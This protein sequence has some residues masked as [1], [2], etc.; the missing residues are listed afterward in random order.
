[1]PGRSRPAPGDT[2]SWS[3]LPPSAQRVPGPGVLSAE[4]IH[5]DA[6]TTRAPVPRAC[7]QQG[8]HRFPLQFWSRGGPGF[9]LPLQLG[10]SRPTRRVDLA[11]FRRD[12]VASAVVAS[13][14]YDLFISHNKADKPFAERL[15]AA[16]EAD[17]NGPALRVFLDK[18]DIG[19][20]ADIPIEL[21]R[22]L[23][24]SRHIGLVLSPDSLK[25]Q[26]V[27]LERS[28]A[29]AGDPAARKARLVPL[30]RRD[31]D[32]PSMLERLNFLDF[33]RDADFDAALDQLVRFLRGHPPRRGEA[34]RS[35]EALAFAEDAALLA[36]H[37]VVFQRPAF[38]T[39]CI[40]ELFLDELHEALDDTRA[41][42]ATGRL[43]SRAGKLMVEFPNE[44]KYR[45][46]EFRDAIQRV[47]EAITDVKRALVEFENLIAA[48]VPSDH[49]GRDF[50]SL[51]RLMRGEEGGQQPRPRRRQITGRA[52]RLMD[53]IDEARNRVLDAV[54]PLLE[55]S[56]ETPLQRIERSSDIATRHFRFD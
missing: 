37:R 25:S 43:Y 42:L 54:N 35:A 4:A 41:A 27:T 20:G 22:A 30:L 34:G 21:E 3:A 9:S 13:Y 8:R 33:R 53:A 40:H 19:P 10:R 24:D 31:V 38:W 12:A 1:M 51:L 36:R 47:H 17:T 26:W 44:N 6:R 56:G 14:G 5:L 15:G 39:S 52:L 16:I 11:H 18:W 50:Y 23:D 49:H 29:I 28:A 7:R 45:L 32:L 2:R 55:R 46:P 48:E